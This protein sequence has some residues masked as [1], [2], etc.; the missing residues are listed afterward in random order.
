MT[1]AVLTRLDGYMGAAG[2]D[3]DH[4]WRSEIA[5]ALAIPRPAPC[6]AKAVHASTVDIDTAAGIIVDLLKLAEGQCGRDGDICQVKS[7]IRAVGRY[8]D[9]IMEFTAVIENVGSPMN[10]EFKTPISE[11]WVLAVP[12]SMPPAERAVIAWDG[13]KSEPCAV[14]YDPALHAWIL[15][16][17][18]TTIPEG[19]ITHWRYC[20]APGG[21]DSEGA[22]S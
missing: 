4:P 15:Q 18:P 17:D 16:C 14:F 11:C 13:A 5:A 6:V 12:R 9:D 8:V 21:I 2:Y 3:T 19:P 22:T 1:A 20:N 10:V 7:A